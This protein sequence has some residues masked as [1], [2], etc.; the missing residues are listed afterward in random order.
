MLTLM[1]IDPWVRPS[2]TKMVP[3]ASSPEFPA[4]S[5]EFTV[6]HRALQGVTEGG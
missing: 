6:D 3:P 5:P 1:R 2:T 4:S